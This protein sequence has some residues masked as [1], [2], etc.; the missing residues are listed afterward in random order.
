MS[1][2]KQKRD[3]GLKTVLNVGEKKT[4]IVLQR[5]SDDYDLNQTRHKQTSDIIKHQ[6]TIDYLNENFP[7]YPEEP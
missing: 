5:K 1:L 2:E 7:S 4:I 3:E 6:H